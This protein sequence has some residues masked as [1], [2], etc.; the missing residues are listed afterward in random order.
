MNFGLC[1]KAD[2]RKRLKI[3]E[4]GRALCPECAQPLDPREPLGGFPWRLAASL[5][6][7]FLMSAAVEVYRWEP[8]LAADGQSRSTMEVGMRILDRLSVAGREGSAVASSLADTVL[9]LW[10]GDEA[11]QLRTDP[12]AAGPGAGIFP[13]ESARKEGKR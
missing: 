6:A 13:K 5:G 11:Q 9:E 2:Q 10:R 1:G 12:Q 4:G 3:P 8:G 7:I